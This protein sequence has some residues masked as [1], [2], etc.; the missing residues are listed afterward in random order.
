MIELLAPAGDMEKL[1][2]AVHFGANAVY[3]AGKKFGLR[4]FAENFT[5]DELKQAVE[6]AHERG[7]KVYVTVNVYAKEEDF[8]SLPEY[9]CYLK[10]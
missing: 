4:A 7:V 5:E 10:A 9:L 6:Y 1:K 8:D 3:M 2:T